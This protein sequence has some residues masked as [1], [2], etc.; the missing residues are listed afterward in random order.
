MIIIIKNIIT[1]LLNDCGD[2]LLDSFN[3]IDYINF[4]Q[5]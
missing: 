5:I 2:Y 1:P 4:N 3:I